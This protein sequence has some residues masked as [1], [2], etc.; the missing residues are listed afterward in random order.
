MTLKDLV[1]PSIQ[2]LVKHY[3]ANRLLLIH[4]SSR[5]RTLLIAALID[6]PP[7]PL[8]YYSLSVQDVTLDQFLTGLAHDLADQ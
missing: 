1:S 3:I 4:P 7:C 2:A 8:Y 6:D 5:Y